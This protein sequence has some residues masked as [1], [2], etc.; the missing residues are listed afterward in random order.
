MI[1][2]RFAHTKNY[3]KRFN[4]RATM[5]WKWA[6][7]VL[8]LG[9]SAL[10]LSFLC[11]WTTGF[12][13][14][15]Y[16]E[17]VLKQMDVEMDTKPFALSGVWGSLWGVD[18]PSKK[19]VNL[20]AVPTSDSKK[21]TDSPTQQSN[22]RLTSKAVN[23]EQAL[24]S[25]ASPAASPGSTPSIETEATPPPSPSGNEAA[26]EE[27]DAEG[28]DDNAVPVT[29]GQTQTGNSQLTDNQRQQLYAT[30]V[31][32]LNPQQLKVLSDAMK[33]GTTPEQIA[34][35]QRMLKSALTDEEY[36]Q[37][38]DILEGKASIALEQ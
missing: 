32:K 12:I 38:M 20:D 23:D 27:T 25:P 30:I 36:D 35:V 2:E 7:W 21:T 17:S 28:T 9:A 13:V 3:E 4:R 37:M 10:L 16:V 11:I 5:M 14:N 1:V 6:S 8:K 31:A 15:S 19:E 24:D 29:G 34:D 33:G 18:D 22:D 26:G